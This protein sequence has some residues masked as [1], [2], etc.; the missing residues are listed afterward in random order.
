MRIIF[1]NQQKE[2]SDVDG[3][4]STGSFA[5]SNKKTEESAILIQRIWRGHQARIQFKDCANILQKKRTQEYIEYY[6]YHFRLIFFLIIIVFR[7]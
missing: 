2:S 5:G 7:C 1:R 6:K 4:I 3:V